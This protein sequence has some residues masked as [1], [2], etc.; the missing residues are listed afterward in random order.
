MFLPVDTAQNIRYTQHIHLRIPT[1][2]LCQSLEITGV[3]LCNA[4]C[5]YCVLALW[6]LCKYLVIVDDHVSALQLVC[7]SLREVKG[8]RRQPS[9]EEPSFLSVLAAL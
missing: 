5:K 8:C 6:A 3:S 1:R 9:C 4:P 7:N 2:G